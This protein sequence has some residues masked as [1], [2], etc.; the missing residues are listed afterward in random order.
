MDIRM[1]IGVTIIRARSVP[2]ISVVVRIIRHGHPQFYGYPS[3]YPH[4]QFNQGKRVPNLLTLVRLV[5]NVKRKEN[6]DLKHVKIVSKEM[7]LQCGIPQC[8]VNFCFL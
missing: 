2:W 7:R 4:G 3:G 1:D 8:V 5:C 6:T